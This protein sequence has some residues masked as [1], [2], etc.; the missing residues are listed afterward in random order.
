MYRIEKSDDRFIIIHPRDAFDRGAIEAFFREQDGAS[1]SIHDGDSDDGRESVLEI[2]CGA[3]RLDTVVNHLFARL[4]GYPELP[5]DSLRELGSSPAPR[6]S[7]IVLM[8][9]ND[10]F[11]R[12]VLLPS[13]L[14]HS[15]GHE[16]EILLVY[17]GFGVDRRPFERFT[18]I[19]S[20]LACISK[21]YNAGVRQAR[22]EYVALFHDDCYL[23]D[24]DWIGKA[25]RA[26]TG[27]VVCVV[28]ECDSWYGAQVGKAVPLVMR[29]DDHLRLG[30]YDEYYYVGVEDMDLSTAIQ[31]AGLRQER[32]DIGYRHL[33]GMGS[34][35]VVHEDPHQLKHAFGYQVLSPAAIRGVHLES[36]RRLLEHDFIRLLEAQYHLHFLDKFEGWLDGRT[37]VPTA[38]LRDLY[39]RKRHPFLLTPAIACI[40][41]REKL[42]EEFR[43]LMNVESLM[44]PAM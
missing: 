20:E 40:S 11:V 12:N 38:A 4:N 43:G 29:R 14:H 44:R 28:P 1:F 3:D 15:R 6:I 27:D 19:E 31:A 35:L 32:V 21:G 7:C 26:L 18:A 13:I 9:F 2:R 30:G 36:M 34:T 22:G 37:T 42:L 33:R 5:L 16:I 8:P 25:L 10:L 41:N 24:P 23:D 17:A 39:E